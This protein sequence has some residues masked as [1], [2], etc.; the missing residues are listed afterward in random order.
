MPD[1]NKQ[2]PSKG[3]LVSVVTKIFVARGAP[4]GVYQPGA[5]VTRTRLGDELVHEDQVPCV[6]VAGTTDYLFP[7]PGETAGSLAQALGSRDEND[8]GG[9]PPPITTLTDRGDAIQHLP[10][11]R[12]A[13]DNTIKPPSPP[14][15][16][17]QGPVASPPPAPLP[18]APPPPA[19]RRPRS[20][21]WRR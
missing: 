15:P 19:P 12:H 17:N 16:A 11:D 4:C 21:G 20:S 8:G 1:D 13:E 18:P 5:L 14:V 6:W 2:G 3:P 7:S 9:D 10:D